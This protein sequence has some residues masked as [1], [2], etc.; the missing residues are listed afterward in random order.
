MLHKLCHLL[1]SCQG[2]GPKDGFLWLTLLLM[3]Q[4][5]YNVENHKS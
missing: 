2:I 4:D 1:I 3:S 5:K